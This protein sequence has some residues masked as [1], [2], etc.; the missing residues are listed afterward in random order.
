MA[1]IDKPD[2]LPRWASQVVIS[3]ITGVPNA[4]E[5]PESKKNVGWQTFEPPA[6]NFF[7]WL[8]KKTYEW[9]LYLEDRVDNRNRVT[10]GDG[11]ELFNKENVLITLYAVDTTAPNNFIHA[12]GFR[13]TGAPIL[14]TISNN[15][16]TLGSSS[17]DGTQAIDGGNASDIIIY[18]IM[19]K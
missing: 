14:N 19:Q 17:S 3:P 12:M 6:R 10:D 11:A 7:N 16:L 2:A 9:L 1:D 4:V 13:G 18:G 5:P 8:H 15:V